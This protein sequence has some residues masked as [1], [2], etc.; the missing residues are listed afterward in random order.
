MKT[1]VLIV[2]AGP[3]GLSLAC[4]LGVRDVDVLLVERRD[5][6]VTVPKMS[7]VS[8]R[9]MEFCR[10]WGIAR[11]VRGAVWPE[12]HALDIVYLENLSGRELARVKIPSYK[13]RGKL[14]FTPEGA[15]H[16]PQI[17]F[18]PILSAR[19]R[20]MPNVDF[21]YRTSLESFE[22]DETGVVAR[23]T[24]Q[25][26][27]DEISVR[28]DYLV[29][30]DGPAGVV[31]ERLG[32]GLG[33]LGVVARSLNIFFRSKELSA[34]HD[35]GWAR[36]YRMVD[37]TGCW[38]ELIPI[39]GVELW[40]LTVFEDATEGQGASDY[41]ARFAGFEFSWDILSVSPWDRRDV[42]ADS[43]GSGRVFVAGDAAH[44]CSPTA[45][46]G[47]HMGIED[48]VNIGWK[49][50]AVLDG[51]GGDA[52]LA[53]YEAERRQADIRNVGLSTRSFHELAEL[54][55]WD[56]HAGKPVASAGEAD[57]ETWRMHLG[58]MS[59]GEYLKL[60]YCYEQSPICAPADGAPPDYTLKRFTPSTRPGTRAP[61][62]WLADG[63]STLDLFGDGFVLLRLGAHAP[64]CAALLGAAR[65]K[66]V[67]IVAHAIDDAHVCEI[68]EQALVLVR[69]DGHVAWRGKAPP[70]DP[71][72]LIDRI[73]GAS[74][75]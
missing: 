31:R 2:G 29:G 5:G 34:A 20:A 22:Q 12:S 11:Q 28:A 24:D 36:M 33:G 15:C 51:W 48:A 59:G 21:R 70:T 10:R 73:R 53:S 63:S 47:M 67:P 7:V 46:M 32:I 30:C 62:A 74:P 23:I 50:A 3:V 75:S 42:V 19:V 37:E 56:A 9:N 27:R 38:S 52:L 45:G 25:G 57:L 43:F 17:Y 6:S 40:R 55:G 4:E 39:D 44:Q 26:A 64:D 54:P 8:S 58:K 16:C 71:G 35:K 13:E 18:D 69:P 49:L 1:S 60:Q 14:D 68:Y 61:H 41:I 72:A 65:D 66:D